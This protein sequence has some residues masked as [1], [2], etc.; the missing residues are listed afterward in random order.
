MTFASSVVRVSSI[1][2]QGAHPLRLPMRP[3]ARHNPG[4][5]RNDGLRDV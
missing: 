1:T 5:E 2:F 4:I 3:P